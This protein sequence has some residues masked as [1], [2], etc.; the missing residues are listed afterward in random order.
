M[1]DDEAGM[2]ETVHAHANGRGV[3]EQW[4]SYE[5]LTIATGV[6]GGPP[7]LY[8]FS[9]AVKGWTIASVGPYNASRDWTGELLLTTGYDHR[10]L[11][12]TRADK[13]HELVSYVSPAGRHVKGYLFHTR[14][15]RQCASTCDATPAGF[16]CPYPC[17][18][19]CLPAGR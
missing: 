18:C 6:P 13:R 2:G 10:H 7:G 17:K 19:T 3:L 9:S 15:V 1:H 11:L 12:D 5:Q 16:E 14:C 4:G 8:Q